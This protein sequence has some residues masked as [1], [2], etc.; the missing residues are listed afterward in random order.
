[1]SL[2]GPRP[3]LERYLARYT[4]EQARRNDVKPGLTGWAQVNGRNAITW[5]NKFKLDVWYVDNLSFSTDLRILL[6]T[7]V[8]VISKDGISAVGEI[9][10]PEFY[11]SKISEDQT[12]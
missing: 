8:K 12:K 5:E 6:L 3:L 1:M 2:V 10:S 4:R 7:I 11:G 9:S